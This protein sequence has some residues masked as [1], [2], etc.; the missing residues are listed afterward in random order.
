MHEEKVSQ[1]SHF[2]Q[3][4]KIKLPVILGKELNFQQILSEIASASSDKFVKSQNQNKEAIHALYPSCI[5][6]GTNDC[7]TTCLHDIRASLLN[8]TTLT[9]KAAAS[10][11]L[12]DYKTGGDITGLIGMMNFA[13]RYSLRREVSNLLDQQTATDLEISLTDHDFHLH[14]EKSMRLTLCSIRHI[15]KSSQDQDF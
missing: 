12:R 11:L 1:R 7:K 4:F 10:A 15:L 5:R 13:R 14:S 9:K 8:V 2:V 3:S 6:Q